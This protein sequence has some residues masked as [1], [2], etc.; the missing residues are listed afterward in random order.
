MIYRV[1]LQISYYENWFDF[2]NIEDAGTFAENALRHCVPS[3][4]REEKLMYVA[5]KVIDPAKTEE[6]EVK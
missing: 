1:I 5:I 6:E 4:D 2:D 3:E